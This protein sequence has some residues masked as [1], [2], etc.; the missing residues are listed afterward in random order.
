MRRVVCAIVSGSR[1]EPSEPRQRRQQR[2]I[3]RQP[4]TP[5]AHMA[6]QQR[7]LLRVFIRVR[8]LPHIPSHAHRMHLMC[9]VRRMLPPRRRRRRREVVSL[10]LSLR[11]LRAL[12]LRLLSACVLL[13]LLLPIKH[14]VF[15]HLV[16]LHRTPRMRVVVLA[17]VADARA[18]MVRRVVCVRRRVRLRAATTQH[19]CRG[20]GR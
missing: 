4:I 18:L 12:L 2:T 6:R 13:L 3:R 20:I 10:L 9:W 7:L 1:L 8:Q 17:R 14:L 16:F 19:R 11:A 15:V 5:Q